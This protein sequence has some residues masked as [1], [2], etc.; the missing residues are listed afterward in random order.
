MAYLVMT[1]TDKKQEAEKIAQTLV[2][3]KIAACV[4]ILGPVSSIYRWEQKVTQSE[5][6]LLFI[7]TRK[8]LY[9]M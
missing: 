3:E 8:D 4:Q 2:G 6:F 1:T 9:S 7:K 5:E